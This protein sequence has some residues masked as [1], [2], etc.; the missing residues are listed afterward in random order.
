MNG[1]SFGSE[2]LKFWV[3]DVTTD[4]HKLLKKCMSSRH[5]KYKKK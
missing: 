5:E 2:T 4:S 3:G 1:I